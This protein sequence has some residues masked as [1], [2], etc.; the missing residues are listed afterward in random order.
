M[1]AAFTHMDGPFERA[2]MDCC[3]S[4]CA[5]FE[6]LWGVNPMGAHTY[7]TA[8]EAAQVLV[9]AGGWEAYTRDLAARAGLVVCD[10]VPGAIGLIDGGQGPALAL[11]VGDAWAAK[12]AFGVAFAHSHRLAWGLPW[13]QQ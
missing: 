9:R 11:C 12:G 1:A 7:A 13:L 10:P 8:R 6:A 4:A 2:A 5:A 3:R